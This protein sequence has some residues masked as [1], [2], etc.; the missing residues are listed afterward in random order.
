MIA[1]TRLYHRFLLA[2]VEGAPILV[3][4]PDTHLPFRGAM[5]NREQAQAI[6]QEIPSLERYARSLTRDPD[7]AEDLVQE[8]LLRAVSRIHQFQPGTNLRA[9][10]FT[11]LRNLYSDAMRRKQRQG[12]TVPIEEWDSRVKSPAEQPRALEFRDFRRAFFRLPAVD[13]EI[14]LLVGVEGLS[15]EE[16]AESLDVALGTVKSRLFRARERLRQSELDL[17][18]MQARAA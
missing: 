16:A 3:A 6:E 15:Y 14:L 5:L 7:S 17:G 4:N 2:L 18:G 12:P 8:S 9:W 13:Q 10:L 1:L 11:I